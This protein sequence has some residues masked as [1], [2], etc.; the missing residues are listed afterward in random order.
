MDSV[1]SYRRGAVEADFPSIREIAHQLAL[2]IVERAGIG[3]SV[4][5]DVASRAGEGA[6]LPRRERAADRVAL[7]ARDAA[8][9][10]VR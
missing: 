6:R 4:I 9:L 1:E 5:P 10:P 8:H 3:R 2:R 7:V